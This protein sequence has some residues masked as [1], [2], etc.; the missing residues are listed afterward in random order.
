MEAD[1]HPLAWLVCSQSGSRY[2]RTMEILLLT[3]VG[4]EIFNFPYRDV[5]Q[6][7]RGT[8]FIAVRHRLVSVLLPPSGLQYVRT[9]EI[10]PFLE[11]EIFPTI[12]VAV[13]GDL[14]IGL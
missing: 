11:L 13:P 7:S 8:V 9:S 6:S 5:E 2:A 4:L 1:V 12:E 3:L 14:K 10:V